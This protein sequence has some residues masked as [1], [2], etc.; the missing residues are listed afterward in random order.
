M[1]EF[2]YDNEAWTEEVFDLDTPVSTFGDLQPVAE[3]WHSKR[4]DGNLPKWR[5][6]E[7]EDFEGWYGWICV[8]DVIGSDPFDFQAR[9][10]GTES[11]YLTG[12]DMTGKSP[13]LNKTE[14]YEFIG[15]YTQEDMNFLAGL[16]QTVRIGRTDGH[17]FWEQ[18]NH[19]RFQDLILPLAADGKTVDSFLTATLRIMQDHI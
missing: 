19:I 4:V 18:R 6:F 9:L 13:R 11:V 1:V 17:V 7:L 8:Y 5:D 2:P 10:W 12:H 14:P 3:L 16:Q 15:E